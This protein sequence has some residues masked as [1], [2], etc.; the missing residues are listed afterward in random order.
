MLRGDLTVGIGNGHVR[1]FLKLMVNE[2][3]YQNVI[4]TKDLILIITCILTGIMIMTLL[5]GSKLH[6]IKKV[7]NLGR[8]TSVEYRQGNERHYYTQLNSFQQS[9]EFIVMLVLPWF[10][11]KEYMLEDKRRTRIFMYI[12]FV[13]TMILI[14]ISLI[15]MSH[16]ILKSQLGL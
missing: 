9:L 5:L 14:F 2:F 1:D 11:R 13:V 15:L 3:G 8:V 12:F 4:M 7:E 6:R 10:N 16:P